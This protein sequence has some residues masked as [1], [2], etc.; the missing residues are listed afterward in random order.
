M[1]SWSLKGQERKSMFSPFYT[2][3][4]SSLQ[5]GYLGN[6]MGIVFYT[7][8]HAFK[9]KVQ[10]LLFAEL[11]HNQ[12]KKLAWLFSNTA[13]WFVLL[14]LYILHVIFLVNNITQLVTMFFIIQ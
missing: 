10:A 12:I 13:Y 7:S 8:I 4:A 9:G 14:S 3:V 1:C 11:S 6:Y 2:L 5:L